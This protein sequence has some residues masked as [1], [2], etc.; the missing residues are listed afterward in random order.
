MKIGIFDSGVGGLFFKQLLQEKHPEVEVLLYNP[1]AAFPLGL[2]SQ[3]EIANILIESIQALASWGASVIVLAC[4]TA[5]LVFSQIS[6]RIS[7]PCVIKD[8]YTPT[9]LFLTKT[10]PSHS[11]FLLS[12]TFTAKHPSY[13]QAHPN[14]EVYPATDLIQLIEEN[15]P[16]KKEDALA[17]LAPLATKKYDYIISGCSHLG[18][19]HDALHE[20]WPQAQIV[21]P[22][23][24]LLDT[25]SCYIKKYPQN[26]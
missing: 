1:P 13:K 14:I 19:I 22:V 18:W 4:H 9:H 16:P 20:A 2:K 7:W 8:L 11:P 17:L 25:I 15:H 23:H 3:D 24:L 26:L 21:E 12:S 5:S 6:P 10:P